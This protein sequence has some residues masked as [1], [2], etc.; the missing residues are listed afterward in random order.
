MALRFQ[1]RFTLI[2][3]VRL[4]FGKKGVSLSLGPRGCSINF[5]SKGTHVNLGIPGTGLSIRNRIDTRT[6]SSNNNFQQAMNNEALEYI[7]VS[8][9]I[10][11]N[12]ILLL[13]TEDGSPLSTTLANRLKKEQPEMVSQALRNGANDINKDFNELMIIHQLTPAPYQRKLIFHQFIPPYPQKPKLKPVNLLYRVFNFPSKIEKENNEKMALYHQAI[14]YWEN[15]KKENDDAEEYFNSIVQQA[16]GGDLQAMEQIFSYALSDL[17]WAKD[18]QLSYDFKDQSI[19]YLDVDLPNLDDMPKKTAEIATRGYKLLIK[20]RTE[21]QLKKDFNY[22]IHSIFFRIA[23]EVFATLPIL[24]KIILS[25]YVQRNDPAVGLI[26]DVYII[27]VEI[28]KQKWVEIDFGQL[29]IIN[30]IDALERFNL[31]KYLDKSSYLCQIDP[32]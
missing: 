30:P 14:G 17:K 25:G 24:Q 28:D 31:R 20:E 21:T 18:T 26:K 22:L 3:G 15:L 13:E 1:K 7:S 29:N 5:G 9:R 8:L 11:E 27:S 19:L 10:D 16:D 6:Q 32:I 23:G 2:P 12:G 4:S